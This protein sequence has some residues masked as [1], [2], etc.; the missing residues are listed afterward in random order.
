[1][2]AEK[3]VVPGA[4]NVLLSHNPDVF[5]VAARQGYA[6][7]HRRPHARRA[8]SRGNPE[9]RSESGRFYTPYVDGVYRKGPASIFVSRGIGTI[10]IPA[11]LGAPPEVALRALMPYLILSDIHANLE[12]L[13]GGARDARGNYDRILCLGDLVGYGADPNAIV[14]WAREN[15]TVDHP[16]QSRP[17]QRWPGS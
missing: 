5:P 7:D 17:G 3:L 9:R 16:R 2:G 14:E 11:R 6:V 8:D 1:M 10:A 4:F 15:V 12:A 13:A